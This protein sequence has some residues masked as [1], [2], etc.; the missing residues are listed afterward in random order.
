MRQS[1]KWSC[2]YLDGD[3]FVEGVFGLTWFPS[4]KAEQARDRWEAAT[5]D[6]ITLLTRKHTS[7][8]VIRALYDSGKNVVMIPNV[9]QDA[10]A[11]THPESKQDATRKGKAAERCVP[12]VTGSNRGSGAGT[13]S[14]IEFS[15]KEWVQGTKGKAG[16]AADEI[17]MHELCHAIR[18]AAGQRNQCFEG[19]VRGFRNQEEFVAVTIT[20]VFSSETHRALRRD[21][22]G[23]HRLPR[24][25]AVFDDR[26]KKTVVDLHDPEVFCKS[27]RRQL[28]EFK[29]HHSTL[30]RRLASLKFIRWNPFAY[31]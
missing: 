17:L 14:K 1:T 18:Y 30:A 3:V 20:N 21:Y 22:E 4:A 24:Q 11:T 6:V 29:R 8:S 5:D 27:Y 15:P 10:N 31:L 28:T 25:T 23:F 19:T 2:I 12:N 9:D 7:W 13:N 16:R 26:G